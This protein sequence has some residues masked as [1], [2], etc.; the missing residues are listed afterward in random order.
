MKFFKNTIIATII[1]LPLTVSCVAAKK[2]YQD[3]AGGVFNYQLNF[4]SKGE[5]V[6]R[7][8]EGNII[9]GVRDERPIKRIIG[10]KTFTV[11]EGEGSH[12]IWIR[13]YK[14]YIPYH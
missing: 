7:D 10:V 5:I 1:L 8:A 6:V 11:I 13:G 9:K 4:D 3:Q 14:Y 12:F 2:D